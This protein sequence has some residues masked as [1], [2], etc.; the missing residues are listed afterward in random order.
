MGPLTTVLGAK[1]DAML[2]V[3]GP[4][5]DCNTIAF[6]TY[7]LRPKSKG[8]IRLLSSDP[9]APPL[10]DPKYFDSD[11]DLQT[12]V[13]GMK[14][15]INISRTEPFQKLGFKLFETKFPDCEQFDDVTSD[16]Y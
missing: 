2:Q 14:F 12:L 8:T 15:A 1:L 3:F 6:L 5:I 10:I 11:E 7:I 13:E 16:E 9:F 4:Y